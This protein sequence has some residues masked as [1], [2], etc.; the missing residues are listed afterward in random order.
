MRVGLSDGFRLSKIATAIIVLAI[1]GF[2]S[3]L[4]GHGLSKGSTILVVVSVLTVIL[5]LAAYA[6]AVS[7]IVGGLKIKVF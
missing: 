6:A 7:L 3:W 2:A 4:L 1:I 5:I